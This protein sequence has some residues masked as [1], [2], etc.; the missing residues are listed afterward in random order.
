MMLIKSLAKNTFALLELILIS[1]S[2]K[3]STAFTQSCVFTWPRQLTNFTAR[4]VLRLLFDL[5]IFRRDSVLFH[6]QLANQFI[7]VNI[8]NL[9]TCFIDELASVVSSNPQ[10]PRLSSQ[11]VLDELWDLLGKAAFQY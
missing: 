1:L 7:N 4:I 10:L 5:R 8:Y 3:F 9:F 2:I 6:P 11:I